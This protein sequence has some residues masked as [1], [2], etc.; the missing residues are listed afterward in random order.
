[1]N[2]IFGYNQNYKWK[3]VKCGNEFEQKIYSTGHL[4]NIDKYLPRCLICYPKYKGFSNKE[5]E[6]FNFCKKYND[7]IIK[8]DRCIIYP[9]ELDIVIPD[10]KLA[11]EFNGNFYH[12]IT[13]I[14]DNYHLNKIIKCNKKGYR[15]IHIWEDEWDNNKKEI[16]EK[17]IDIFNSEEKLTFYEQELILDRSWYNNII[18]PNYIL[19]KELPPIRIKRKNYIVEDCGYLIYKKKN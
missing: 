17:L 4:K 13:H 19:Y 16:K 11:I 9:Y 18:I 15:L 2:N 5:I 10:K 12:D 1:M 3:C 14:N 8:S 6:L 7:N